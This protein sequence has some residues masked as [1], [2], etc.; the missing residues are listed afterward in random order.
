MDTDRI[1]MLGG[2]D[3]SDIEENVLESEAEGSRDVRP[4]QKKR[5]RVASADGEGDDNVGFF[6]AGVD[7]VIKEIVASKASRAELE[8]I[9]FKLRELEGL[10]HDVVKDREYTRGR[11]AEREQ[12]RDMLAKIEVERSSQQTG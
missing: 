5:A 7:A 1:G 11:L 8:K 3:S 2:G 4:R 10:F 12:F 9:M 6:K